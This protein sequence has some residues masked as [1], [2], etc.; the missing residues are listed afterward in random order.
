MF[1]KMMKIL[2]SENQTVFHSI[3]VALRTRGLSVNLVCRTVTIHAHGTFD[4]E[5]DAKRKSELH[6]H[7]T[8]PVLRYFYVNVYILYRHLNL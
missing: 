5:R 2:C 8:H 3:T 1:K 6:E 7:T 4:R